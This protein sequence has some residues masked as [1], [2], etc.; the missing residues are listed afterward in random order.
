M[1]LST[2]RV[3]NRPLSGKE[4]RK[5]ILDHVEEMLA[6][7]GML[8][9]YIGYG[10]VAFTVRVELHLDNPSTPKHVVRMRA[11]A[12]APLEGAPPLENPSGEA[13]ATGSE[14]VVTVD[15][16]NLTRMYHDMPIHVYRNDGK[17]GVAE[18]PVAYAKEGLPEL[19]ALEERDISAELETKWKPVIGKG[20]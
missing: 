3:V 8:A 1:A 12:E 9:E 13:V 4:L 19:P 14:R 10:R 17:G 5:V 16:P 20:E 11:S 18:H 7:D 2:E 15:S 6:K